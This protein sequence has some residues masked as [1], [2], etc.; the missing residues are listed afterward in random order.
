MTLDPFRDEAAQLLERTLRHLEH[1]VGAC[2]SS[3]LVLT[4][5]RLPDQA[6]EYVSRAALLD[7]QLSQLRRASVFA[8]ESARWLLCRRAPRTALVTGHRSA[9]GQ[10]AAVFSLS[11]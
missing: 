4:L 5:E 7:I 1:Q 9:T 11:S 10:V 6:A 3:A 8:P 2:L